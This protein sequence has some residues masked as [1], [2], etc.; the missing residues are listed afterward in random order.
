[1]K[2]YKRRMEAVSF[3]DRRAIEER[4]T[5]MAAQ[6]WMVEQPGNYLWRY[7]RME[8]KKLHFAVTYFP[9]A[10]GFDPGPT[11][12][13]QQMEEYCARDGWVS[14]VRWGQMQ[15]FYNERENPMPIETDPVTQ[16]ATIHRTMRKNMWGHVVL[17]ALCLYQLIFCFLQLRT[18]PVDFLSTPL[19]LYMVIFWLMLPISPLGEL[20]C[21]RSWHR[22]A[23]AAAEQG[24]FL[25]IKSRPRESA[26]LLLP[27]VLVL[28]AV[29]ACIPA[30]R[31][32][33]VVWMLCIVSICLVVNLAM[34]WM[35]K[36]GFSRSWN[37]TISVA[38]S[39]LLTIA[40]LTGVTV[41]VIRYR[42]WD[43]RE[44][45]GTYEK[46]GLSRN[47]Y[48]YDIPLRIEDLTGVPPT[49]WSTEAQVSETFLLRNTEYMQWPLS[50][51]HELPQLE[52]TVTEVK[53]PFLY[54]FCKNGLIRPDDEVRDGVVVLAD[55]YE[56]SDPEPWGAQAAYRLYFSDGYLNHYLLCYE[57]RL[58]ELRLDWEPTAAQ[59][60]IVTEALGK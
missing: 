1:M 44:P 39:A 2:E 29:F 11:E 60:A 28:V 54:E 10:S 40:L 52:Y 58:V 41:S 32:F 55:H 12:G 18:D 8:P 19:R 53:A 3:Y 42:L 17:L 31:E 7:R 15:I 51:D 5:K 47:V 46:Y 4:L 21:Y 36:K 43:T 48:A 33:V 27:P 26:M 16:V 57:N 50:E 23:I 22:R 24:E 13:Q 59:M 49:D 25:E 30:Y 6:G 35:K 20:L 9:N 14:V 56:P 34:R 37:R 45:V 38:I